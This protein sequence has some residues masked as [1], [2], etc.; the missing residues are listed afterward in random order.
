MIGE[1]LERQRDQ[2][3]LH[4]ARRLGDGNDDIR[5]VPD[6]AVPFGGHR[7]DEPV[8]RLHLFY[9]ARDLLVGRPLRETRSLH[10]PFRKACRQVELAWR[11]RLVP[12]TIT[13][14]PRA[15]SQPRPPRSAEAA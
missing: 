1:E 9:V 15:Y 10:A 13:P 7:D 11:Y 6:L 12:G 14:R 4:P 2:Q 8:A 5:P 3:R